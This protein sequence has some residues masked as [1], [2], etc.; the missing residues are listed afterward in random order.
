MPDG[1]W[2]AV[3][4]SCRRKFTRH[5]RPRRNLR[6]SCCDCGWESGRLKFLR[7]E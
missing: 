6:Y 3:C 4:P 5:R 7:S 1:T 2:W